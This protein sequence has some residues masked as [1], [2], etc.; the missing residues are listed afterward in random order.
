MRCWC[1]HLFGAKCKWFAYGPAN[2]NATPP[3]LASLKSG[4]VQ[5]FWCQLTQDAL[6][7]RPLNGLSVSNKTLSWHWQTVF[8]NWAA[9]G[10]TLALEVT[11]G[12]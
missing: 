9:H 6:K 2:A 11:W 5:P 12:H 4:L 1:D 3:S 8:H 10:V 7:K